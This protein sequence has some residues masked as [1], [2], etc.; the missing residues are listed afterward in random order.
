MPWDYPRR[1]MG[2]LVDAALARLDARLDT[3]YA[4]GGRPSI[5]PEYLLRALLIQLL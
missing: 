5:P 1:K 3:T 2:V 4:K